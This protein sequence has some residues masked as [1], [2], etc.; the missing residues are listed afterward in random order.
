MKT[1]T[2]YGASDDLVEAKGIDGCDEFGAWNSADGPAVNAT[3]RVHAASGGLNIHAVYDGCWAFAVTA[4]NTNAVMPPWP[5]TR[6]WGVEC[7]YSE[8]LLIECPDDARILR[9]GGE[10][11]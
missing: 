2:M 7:V 4:P 9:V 1:L 10:E 8:T 3:F 11:A 6:R 5:I